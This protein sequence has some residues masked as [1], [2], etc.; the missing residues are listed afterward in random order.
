MNYAFAVNCLLACCMFATLPQPVSAQTP[1]ARPPLAIHSRY[2]KG[3]LEEFAKQLE[4]W[5][6]ERK[7]NVTVL[8][9]ADGEIVFEKMV[10][11][12]DL[13]KNKPLKPDSSYRLASVSKQFTAMGIMLLHQD[14]KLQYDDE[15][16][17]YLP[18]LPYAGVTIRHLLNHTGGLPDYMSLFSKHWDPGIPFTKKRIATNKDAVELFAKHKPDPLFSPEINGNTAIP[19]P[20]CWGVSSSEYLE[21]RHKSFS[22]TGFL[23][24]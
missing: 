6:M 2:S 22:N 3:E 16:Q 7:F 18:E 13:E 12:C 17:K 19:V 21:S 4:S 24:R 9:A 8:I 14:G 20:C 15:I 23:I 11:Y 10:G 5:R 1:E